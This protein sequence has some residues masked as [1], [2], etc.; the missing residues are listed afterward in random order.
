MQIKRDLSHL[1]LAP[2][3]T[4]DRL[5]LFDAP[6]FALGYMPAFASYGAQDARVGHALAKA[7]KQLFLAL[8]RF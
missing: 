3:R 1:A 8:A 4:T 2:T 7:P 5:F 6:Q